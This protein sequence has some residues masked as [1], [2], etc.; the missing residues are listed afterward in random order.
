MYENFT[1][2]NY[3]P[4]YKCITERLYFILGKETFSGDCYRYYLGWTKAWMGYHVNLRVIEEES[5]LRVVEIDNLYYVSSYDWLKLKG[6]S[7]LNIYNN[8]LIKRDDNLKR[9]VDL[10]YDEV[11]NDSKY[12]MGNL[13]VEHKWYRVGHTIGAIN[14]VRSVTANSIVI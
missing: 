10:L 2:D 9:Y 14:G 6:M 3:K 13:T 11:I 12:S 8:L 7:D 1:L 5:A 4:L